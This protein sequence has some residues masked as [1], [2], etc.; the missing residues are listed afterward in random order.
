MTGYKGV[1]D[2]V[3]RNILSMPTALSHTLYPATYPGTYLS[4]PETIDITYLAKRQTYLPCVVN[5]YGTKVL[6]LGYEGISVGVRG[7]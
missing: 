2:Q 4:T 7:Y 6:V 1:S 5:G 3:K